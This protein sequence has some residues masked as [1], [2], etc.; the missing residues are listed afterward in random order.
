MPAPFWAAF[1]SLLGLVLWLITR[2]PPRALLRST[3]TTAVAALNRA[4][5]ELV[6][7]VEAVDSPPDTA[8]TAGPEQ[9]AAAAV[10]PPPPRTAFERRTY[11]RQLQLWGAGDPEQRLRAVRAARLWTHPALLPLLRRGLRDGDPRVMAEA[12]A[13]IAAYRGRPV[14]VQPGA[15]IQPLGAAPRRVSRTR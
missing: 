9:S 14:P 4:Q 5:I 2:R 15:G 10:L 6:S 8:A 1:A 12:A 7:R 11:L 13:A 3:D